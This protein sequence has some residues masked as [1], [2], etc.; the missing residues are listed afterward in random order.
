[1]DQ[2]SSSPGGARRNE[3]IALD[4]L[5]FV[6]MT[7]GISRTGAA[8]TGFTGSPAPKQQEDL[9][10]HL[11]ELYSRCLGVVEGKRDAE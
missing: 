5:K 6:S 1:M 3:D 2:V 8:S 10:T 11:L 9:V 4:L 7:A